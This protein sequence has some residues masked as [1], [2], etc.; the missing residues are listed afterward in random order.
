MCM[1]LGQQLDIQTARAAGHQLMHNRDR[2]VAFFA[3]EDLHLGLVGPKRQRDHDGPRLA[4]PRIS[5][6]HA[7]DGDIG[8][9]VAMDHQTCRLG[10][11]ET[12]VNFGVWPVGKD[13]KLLLDRRRVGMLEPQIMGSRHDRDLRDLGMFRCK[14]AVDEDVGKRRDA[15]CQDPR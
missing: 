3:E 4:V 6:V 8:V 14:L 7:V 9:D 10:L 15:H 1:F 5:L 11:V 13:A 12:N 2:L